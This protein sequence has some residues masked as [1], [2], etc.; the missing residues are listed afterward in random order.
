[1]EAI[2]NLVSLESGEAL[3]MISPNELWDWGGK[4]ASAVLSY[5]QFMFLNVVPSNP[6]QNTNNGAASSQTGFDTSYQNWFNHLCIDELGH[7]EQYAK[8][9]NDLNLATDNYQSHRDNLQN[10]W[11]NTTDTAT[12]KFDD[13]L[14]DN[15]G[16]KTELASLSDDVTAKVSQLNDY[17]S[18]IQSTVTNIGN[19]YNNQAYQG[20]IT[21]PASKKSYPVR[22]WNTSP[23]NAFKYVMSITDSNFGGDAKHGT[24]SNISFNKSSN[25]YDYQRFYG[26]TTA[27]WSDFIS[28][29]VNGNYDKF[30]WSTFTENYSLNISFQDIKEVSISPGRWYDGSNIASFAKGPYSTGYSEFNSGG[31]FNVNVGTIPGTAQVYLRGPGT[32]G[33]FAWEPNTAPIQLIN[34]DVGN[35]VSIPINGVAGRFANG[36]NSIL[37]ILY[38]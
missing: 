26:D 33:Q 37:Q 3:Q 9:V 10:I 32:A 16:Y 11:K 2:K 8:L 7:D 1:M 5:D 25:S 22:L 21:D 28:I 31:I 19:V 13:W 18:R 38:N 35:T 23:Q 34:I 4:D 20:N 6:L 14:N 12:I 36:C 17:R 15:I 24:S 27:E 30:D 29:Y